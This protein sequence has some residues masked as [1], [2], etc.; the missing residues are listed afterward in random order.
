[1]NTAELVRQ[2]QGT[3][4]DFSATA[5]HAQRIKAELRTLPNWRGLTARQRE[6]LE[7]IAVKLARIGCGDVNERDHWDDI[8]GY[9]L[10]A[11]EKK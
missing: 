8:A 11:R 9:A 1:M 4:G 3:H 7:M 6:A 5:E 10:L 2:R